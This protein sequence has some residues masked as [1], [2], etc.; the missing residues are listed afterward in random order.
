[1]PITLEVS[2]ASASVVS[3]IKEKGGSVKCIY[4][5]PLK[6]RE[7]IYPERYDLELKDPLPPAYALKQLN[8]IEAR[9]AEVVFREPA[10][11]KSKSLPTP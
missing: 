10:W 9:G 5:T 4:R 11:L 3:A 6:V 2:D 7:H 1:M 8:R